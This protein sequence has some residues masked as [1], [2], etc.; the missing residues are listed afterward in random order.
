MSS[1]WKSVS[2][3]SDSSCLRR[4]LEPKPRGPRL[5]GSHRSYKYAKSPSGDWITYSTGDHPE[6]L[7]PSHWNHKFTESL[8]ATRAHHW[9]RQQP[10][11]HD[12]YDAFENWYLSGPPT[13]LGRPSVLLS[14]NSGLKSWAKRCMICCSPYYTDTWRWLIYHT[15]LRAIPAVS[16]HRRVGHFNHS[17]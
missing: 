15:C 2:A 14:G 3:L 17:L 13:A 12:I 11:R 8:K 5:P 4:W 16:Y 10:T 6:F 1:I 9:W 7:Q